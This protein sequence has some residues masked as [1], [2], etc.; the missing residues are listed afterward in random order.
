[1]NMVILKLNPESANQALEALR[2]TENEVLQNLYNAIHSGIMH[3]DFNPETLAA[4]RAH[5]LLET[6]HGLAHDTRHWERLA[7]KAA[8]IES[9]VPATHLYQRHFVRL[10]QTAY[11]E[12]T[13]LV[14]HPLERNA[15]AQALALETA[16]AL[17]K[18][19]EEGI[20]RLQPNGN[21]EN[22]VLEVLKHCEVVNT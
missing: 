22:A 6:L 8:Y 20:E 3:S 16:P 19:S 12:V 7:G 14:M 2:G 15:L 11:Q 21:L 13:T 4:L 10:W 5:A 9:L 18:H 17:V 1:M